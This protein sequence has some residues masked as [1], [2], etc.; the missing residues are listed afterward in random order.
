MTSRR[1]RAARF[2]PRVFAA[3]LV[4][5]AAFCGCMAAAGCSGTGTTAPRGT[6]TSADGVVLAESQA[7]GTRAY[8][9]G[10]V[11]SP[12]VGSCYTSDAPEG[13]E[14]RYADELLAGNDIQLTIDSCI[15]TAAVEALADRTG[16][17]V[18]MDP[19]T[20]AVLAM[21]STPAYDPTAAKAADTE[22]LANRAAELHIPG[23]TFKTITLAAALESGAFTMESLYPAPA[24]ITFEGG[25]VENYDMIQ[26][27]AQTL[28]QAYAKSINTVFAQ[29][30]LDVG[31]DK[32]AAMAQ[33]FGFERDIMPDFAIRPSIICDADVMQTRMQAW[34]GVG[35]ALYQSDGTLQ[36]PLMSPVQGAVIATAVA[37]GGMA[38][39]PHIVASIGGVPAQT[40]ESPQAPTQVMTPSTAEQLA[41]GMRAVVSEGTGLSAAV[42]GVDVGGKTGTAETANGVDDCWFICFAKQGAQRYAVAVLFEGGQSTAAAVAASKVIQALFS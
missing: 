20:G 26:Y 27:P 6:I 35:Q 29:L 11:A 37:N 13:I 40:A 32:V 31:F 19:A 23:S 15:Q 9:L 28:L 17:I 34:S 21:A 16:A 25:A 7:D 18:V 36:G 10:S 5:F 14:Q 3:L 24:G 38:V 42:A 39:R 8:P 41:L 30:T 22:E 4:L 1:R 2:H 12:V 33:A